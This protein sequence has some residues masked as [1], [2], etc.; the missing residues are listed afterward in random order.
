MIEIET[1]RNLLRQCFVRNDGSDT[2]SFGLTKHT[3]L[4]LR[5]VIILHL[6]NFIS[7]IHINLTFNFFPYNR[8]RGDGTCLDKSKY[9]DG[10]IHCIDAS[11]EEECQ[12]LPKKYVNTTRA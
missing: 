10:I 11:D 1:R 2:I 7:D 6:L 8:C 5:S 12:K 3:L 4:K 9:C